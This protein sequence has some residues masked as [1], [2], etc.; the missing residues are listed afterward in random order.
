MLTPIDYDL[1]SWCFPQGE[2]PIVV[3]A[4]SGHAQLREGSLT[5]DARNNF[6][7]VIIM[8]SCDCRLNAQFMCRAGTSHS[9]D[10]ERHTGTHDTYRGGI[11][12][13]CH[14]KHFIMILP[15]ASL[16]SKRPIFIFI[17]ASERRQHV[18]S[19]VYNQLN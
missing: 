2:C 16:L 18:L 1:A 4:F 8:L 7:I 5:A 17:L 15:K 12:R 9:A 19:I 11:W 13:H 14:T 10:R 6:P 3:G